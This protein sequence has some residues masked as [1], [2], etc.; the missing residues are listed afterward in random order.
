[1]KTA[2]PMDAASR[3]M[4]ED[5]LERYSREHYD[6][7]AW[8]AFGREPD[9]Y[10]TAVWAQLGE[11]GWL[12]LGLPEE[13]GGTGAS[14]CDLL[15]LAMAAGRGLWR[16]PVLE[17][18][19]FA[20]GALL[21]S[22]P[23]TLRDRLLAGI[24][25]GRE[26]LAYAHH[27]RSLADAAATLTTRAEAR[28][29]AHVITGGKS[30]VL[31]AV[32]STGLL[33]SARIAGSADPGLFYV[34][35]DAPGLT[36][37]AYTTVDDRVAADIRFTQTP[38]ELLAAGTATLNAAHTRAAILAAAQAAG[39]LQAV[40]TATLAHLKTRQ[41]FGKPLAQFQALQHRL[42][43]MHILQLESAAL[44]QAVATAYDAQA[45]HLERQLWQLRVQSARAARVVTQQGIQLHGAMGMTDE[46]PIG[47]YYKR[48][49][50]L[51]SLFG[52]ADTAL[53][54]LAAA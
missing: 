7:A 40:N 12:G 13:L 29:G 53:E 35:G 17:R 46:L 45:P 38:A 22:P 47:D 11:F 39:V 3:A 30:F 27:E 37:A 6:R 8:R 1:M 36:L 28:V 42:V 52:S 19:G 26:R 32:S 41:Q 44:V 2:R 31:A 5:S 4:L 9:G 21:A 51:D 24:A 43:D 15:P 48:I 34:K 20:S 33:V 18:L 14:L 50:L 49:L 25:E 23:G 10:A 16:D 54:R